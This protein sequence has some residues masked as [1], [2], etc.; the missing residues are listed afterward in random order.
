MAWLV[1]KDGARAVH[2]EG[3]KRSPDYHEHI[4]VRNYHTGE[5][6]GRCIGSLKKMPN[7]DIW[8]IKS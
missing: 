4:I 6:K 5:I 3:A 7:G 1:G 2:E 8:V